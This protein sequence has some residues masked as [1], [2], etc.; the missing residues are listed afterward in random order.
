MRS[1]NCKIISDTLAADPCSCKRSRM[2][3]S[4]MKFSCSIAI[5]AAWLSSPGFAQ[6]PAG[7]TYRHAPEL[8][9]ATAN[10]MPSS[11]AARFLDQATWGPTLGSIAELQRM[12]ITEWLNRQFSARSS[13]LPDQPILNSEGNANTNLAPVQ[14]AFFQNTLAGEDQ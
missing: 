6:T 4:T 2:A 14:A 7:P 3:R 13:D 11:A 8:I 5:A 10:V 12:G 1:R 9:N